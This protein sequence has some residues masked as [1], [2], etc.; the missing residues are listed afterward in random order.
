MNTLEESRTFRFRFSSNLS[1][2]KDATCL[3]PLLFFLLS[4]SL[5]MEIYLYIFRKI[6]YAPEAHIMYSF[7]LISNKFCNGGGGGEE[8]PEQGD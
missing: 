4:L 6:F 2:V 7:L 5:T 8:R 3:C 1:S